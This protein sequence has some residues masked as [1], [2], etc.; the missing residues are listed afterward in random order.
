M[1]EI[2]TISD[3]DIQRLRQTAR[4]NKTLESLATDLTFIDVFN[5][6]IGKELLKD[7]L[8]QHNLLL[9]LIADPEVEVTVAQRSEYKVCRHLIVTWAGRIER[10]LK[11]V[12]ETGKE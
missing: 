11:S 3:S 9:N 12:G 7:L 2:P 10:Y 5:T 4:G 8:S 1:A 6:K